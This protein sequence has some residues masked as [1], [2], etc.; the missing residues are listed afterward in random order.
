ML[1]KKVFLETV[2]IHRLHHRLD[3]A[4]KIPDELLEPVVIWVFQQLFI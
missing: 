2:P 4:G 1:S 3:Q